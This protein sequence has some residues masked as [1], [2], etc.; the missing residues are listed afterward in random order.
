MPEIAVG[1]FISTEE[2]LADEKVIYMDPKM[3]LLDPDATQYTTMVDKMPS[4]ASSRE[5]FN[6]PAVVRNCL[7]IYNA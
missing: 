6:W 4:R 3:R 1:N 5:K 7:K 2:P